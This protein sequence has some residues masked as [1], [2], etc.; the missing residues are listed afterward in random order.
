M[1]DEATPAPEED[2]SLD[3]R[4]D[5]EAS[6]GPGHEDPDAARE[7]A[8]LGGKEPEPSGAPPPGEAA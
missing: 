8:G 6:R 5:E 4:Q 2:A 7:R 3:R 1:K